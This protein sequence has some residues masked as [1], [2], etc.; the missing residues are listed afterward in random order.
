MV[1]STI[2]P[3]GT[4]N[5]S[6]GQN[7]GVN[8]HAL[9]PNQYYIGVNVSAQSTSLTPRW[10]IVQRE[11][12]FSTAGDYQR[13]T[14]SFVSF[15]NIYLNGKFQSFIP[16]GIGPDKYA[17]YVISGFIF[18]IN[19]S[20]GLVSV[21]NPTDQLNVYAD[22]VN[23][24]NAGNYL[25]I[26]DWPNYP[27]IIDGINIR[28]ADPTLYEVPIAVM[29]AYNQNR[30]CIANA[31][32]DWTAGDPS[33]S[34]ATPS[35]PV[36][37]FEVLYPSSP[38]VGDV[39]QIPTANKNSDAITAMGFLQVVDT[40]TGI[41]PLL[42]ATQNSIYSY[43]TDVPRGQWQGTANSQVFGSMLLPT[44]GVVG[45]R[46]FTNVNSDV[47]FLGKDGQIYALSMSR[48]DQKR[49]GSSPISR[50]VSNFLQYVDPTI[51]FVGV[52]TYYRNKVFT[53]CNPYRVDCISAEGVI[54]TDYV[55]AGVVVMELD[56]NAGLTQDVPPIWTG[57]WTGV[58]FM[59]FAEI[60]ER[61]YIAG[62]HR[63]QNG[64]FYMDPDSTYDTIDGKQRKVR[65]V[66]VTKEYDNTDGTVNKALHSLDLGM[67]SIEE[68]M[69]ISVDY[70][71][72]TSESFIHWKDY[73]YTAPVEQCE[74]DVP[75]PNGLGR[76]G[77]RDLTIGSVDEN[78]CIPGTNDLAHVYKGVQ[79][80]LTIEAKYWELEY[81]KLKGRVLPRNELETA[82]DPT[83]AE[84]APM[85]CF[86][87]W[88]I[89]DDGEC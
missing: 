61:L 54:Q 45:P 29:G 22:R 85:G 76:Q 10:G 32:I 24:S 41:G 58:G 63:G 80:R 42:V 6:G 9:Q 13:E 16:Y 74:S 68:K 72:S 38:Y 67:R 77:I 37:F 52:T 11:L 70:K 35:A 15:E 47:L 79:L 26:F 48:N 62:K 18:L 33:G 34:P 83:D 7:A 75:F 71:P 89:P 1:A 21:M 14:G 2:V 66:L 43:R 44:T 69:D 30:L 3:D 73:T 65:S 87:Y 17:I 27:F 56:V 20:T 51:K 50:E 28:R 40:S 60:D 8:P 5:F 36:T 49:W 23:W 12:D 59:D 53:T 46:A 78:E 82:C 64:L 81:L 31:G 86:D 55:N 19:I 57:L 25:V 4:T 39:Y 84:P 88:L